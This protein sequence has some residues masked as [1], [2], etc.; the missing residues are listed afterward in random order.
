MFISP[1]PSSPFLFIFTS[2]F[3]E[4]FHFSCQTEVF[5]SSTNGITHKKSIS[6]YVCE[7]CG[8]RR[9]KDE[10]NP[11]VCR[12]IILHIYLM[13]NLFIHVK[14]KYFGWINHLFFFEG[15]KGIP[16]SRYTYTCRLI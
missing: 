5:K 8:M 11:K 4:Q 1:I 9:V 3:M 2:T 16:A 7:E 6:F 10:G 14:R 13:G 15:V 12:I